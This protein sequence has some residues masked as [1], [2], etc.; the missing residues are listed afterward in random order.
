VRWRDNGSK[1][2]SNDRKIGLGFEGNT[3]FIRSIFMLGTYR[4]RQWEFY[5]TDNIPFSI[6]QATE[7]VTVT[8]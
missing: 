2:W 6:V 1:I 5:C 4:T 7:D 8:R 3:E